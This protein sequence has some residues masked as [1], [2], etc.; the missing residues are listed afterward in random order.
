VVREREGKWRGSWSKGSK[1]VAKI[2]SQLDM[3][4]KKA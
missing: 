3:I 4:F 2:Y 1:K